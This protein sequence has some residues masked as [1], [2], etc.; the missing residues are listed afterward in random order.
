VRHVALGSTGTR[1]SELCLG[2]MNFGGPT[3]EVEARATIHAALDQGINFIDTADVY[4]DG[5]SERIVGAAIKNCR[6]DIVL[7]TKVHGPVGEGVN[8]WG[9]SRRRI[10]LQCERS[11]ERLQTDRIDLYQLH[12]PDTAT[13][14][15][16][17][18]S[19]LDDLVHAG[20]VMYV[21]VSSFA[22]WQ[23]AAAIERS[24][25]SWPV[26]RPVSDQPQY[27]LLDR[28]LETEVIPMARVYGLAILPWSPLASGLLSGKY[29]DG[30]IPSGSRLDRFGITSD[31]PRATR[32][33]KVLNRLE[34]VAR[35]AGTTLLGL[36]MAWL[37][38]QPTVTA[39]IIGPR[40]RSQLDAYMH[41]LDVEVD[42]DALR[43]IDEIVP[44]GSA[45]LP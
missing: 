32:V 34:G 10:R 14:V 15:D 33:R 22:A 21:G 30:S 4:N 13:T 31:D 6:D 44:R 1:I 18:L 25:R 43:A 35:T 28:R 3:D 42:D 40:D 23:T 12:R 27:N 29:S 24:A 20:K 19:A 11:L 7:A 17:T 2:A 45:V 38:A 36:A 16:E 37:R 26:A 9:S 39:P 8:D 5:A 41:S